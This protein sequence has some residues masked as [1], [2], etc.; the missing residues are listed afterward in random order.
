VH[1][2]PADQ[3]DA[4]LQIF[5]LEEYTALFNLYYCSLVVN[6]EENSI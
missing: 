3:T 1:Y 6:E 4:T 2:P 5:E